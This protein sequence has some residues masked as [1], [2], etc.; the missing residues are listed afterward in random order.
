MSC[1]KCNKKMRFAP[2]GVNLIGF[3]GLIFFF[4]ILLS[5]MIGKKRMRWLSLISGAWLIAVLQFFRD[6]ER[7][8]LCNESQ[9]ISPADGRIIVIDDDP[10]DSPL[11][12]PGRK[13]SIFMSPL[14]V[15]VNRAPMAGKILT[16]EHTPG[17]FLSAFKPEA[18]SENERTVI[19]METAYGI[20]AFKQI[21]GFLARRIVFH[22]EPGHFVEAGQRVGMIKFGSRVDMFIPKNSKIYVQEGDHVSAGETI[23]GEITHEQTSTVT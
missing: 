21:A 14:N 18:S 11:S 22:P 20:I 6:P 8:A 9:I 19:T 17:E 12:F 4:S 2:E 3:S 23:I 7:V 13:I 16:V 5:F 1:P 15:H 10:Q